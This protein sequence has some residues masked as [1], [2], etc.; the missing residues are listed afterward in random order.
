MKKDLLTYGLGA[1][2]LEFISFLLMPIYASRFST[3][4]YGALTFL[5]L[6]TIILGWFLGLQIFS[7]MWRYYCELD[8]ENQTKL[9][10]SSFGFST[11]INFVIL[12]LA[13]IIQFPI[14]KKLGYNHLIII[15]LIASFVGYFANQGV[16]I[17]DYREKRLLF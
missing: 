4:D 10:K 8:G 7:G 12:S 9:V 14:I 5:Q 1:L 6:F 3:A 13:I 11:I 17:L 16:S 2:L 15:V